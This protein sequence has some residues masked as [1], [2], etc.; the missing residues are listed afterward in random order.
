MKVEKAAIM[1]LLLS[2]LLS[3]VSTVKADIISHN[4]IPAAYQPYIVF[5]LNSV[6][7]SN[8]LTLNVNFYAGVWANIQF[9]MVYSLD[10]QENKSLPLLM[11]M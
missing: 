4:G 7:H 11:D 9:T 6:Y 5:P 1:F 2:C 3:L 8:S 10:G